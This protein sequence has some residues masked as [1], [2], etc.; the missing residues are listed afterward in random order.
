M[1]R[2][3]IRDEWHGTDLQVKQ[4]W[5]TSYNRAHCIVQRTLPKQ[6]H[7]VAHLGLLKPDIY[8]WLV[9]NVWQILGELARSRNVMW[10]KAAWCKATSRHDAA[11]W[12][13]H[14]ATGRHPAACRG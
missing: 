13:Y 9:A 4:P 10:L 7:A 1:I 11:K 6:L 14:G 5:L 3:T 2:C 12:C 8:I